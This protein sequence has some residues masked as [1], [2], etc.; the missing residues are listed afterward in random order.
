MLLGVKTLCFAVR[1]PK[2]GWAFQHLP[3]DL[4]ETTETCDIY[5]N[6]TTVTDHESQRQR[7]EFNDV[8]E[9]AGL[10]Y[11]LAQSISISETRGIGND[12][13]ERLI[14]G[15]ASL[16][17]LEEIAKDGISGIVNLPCLLRG[18]SFR[19]SAILQ[20]RKMSGLLKRRPRLQAEIP[21]S[22]KRFDEESGLVYSQTSCKAG[23]MTA[24]WVWKTTGSTREHRDFRSSGPGCSSLKNM[25]IRGV[26]LHSFSLTAEGLKALPWSIGQVLWQRILARYA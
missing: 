11:S 23:P 16:A 20:Y 9:Q 25:A 21:S 17:T 1:A 8:Q 13:I 24:D 6:T 19:P 12:A 18:S 15:L 4:N 2:N 5:K 3:L 10:A 26:L 7:R 14:L 22:K